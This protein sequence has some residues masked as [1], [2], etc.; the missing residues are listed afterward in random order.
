VAGNQTGK[1]A[2]VTGA[3]HGIGGAIADRL[4]ADGAKVL[5]ADI[6]AAF[7]KKRADAIN[8]TGGTAISL[9]VDVRERKQV[10]AMVTRAVSEW[11]RLDIQVS[12]A[13]I[14]D[15][16]PFLEMDDDLWDRVISTN[17][18]GAFI[19][20]QYAAHQMVSQGNGG[21]IVHVASNSGIFGG[22]G[23]A[24]Y[25]ASKAG[26]INLTQTMAIELAEHG[27]LVNAVAPG[28]TRTRATGGEFPP[29]TVMARMPLRRFGEPS[30]IAAVAAFLAS[31]DCSFT[32]GHVFSA[33]G[34]FTVAG[35][36][37]G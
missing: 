28:A 12:N 34:G 10:A 22:R 30:E 16:Q 26:I 3:A 7:A 17:L 5:V 27:I 35:V 32:T 6:E 13:G 36:M 20:G 11:G 18:Y 2:I 37:E 31:D 24:A 9:E 19:C 14:V 25:G 4:A 8:A 33:D 1:V 15:R 23:R 29:D 21:R